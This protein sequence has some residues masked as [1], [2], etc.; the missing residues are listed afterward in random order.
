MRGLLEVICGPMFS[1]KSTELM[2]RVERAAIAKQRVICFKPP[3]DNR[4]SPD[5]LA[6][7]SGLLHDAMP[8]RRSI[9][10]MA[11][12]HR[13]IDVV[14]I[15]EAQ[16]VDVELPKF[17]ELLIQAD[18]TVILSGL[19]MDSDGNPFLHPVLLSR[20]DKITKLTAVCMQCGQDASM[21][22]RLS[23]DSS[24]VLVG[25]T[26][27]YEARCRNCHVVGGIS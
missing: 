11:I 4:Y 9:D 21:T 26:G 3:S 2:R 5:K 24:R 13:D 18:K 23:K 1:G 8:L 17:V 20:A 14:G 15:D 25:A 22:Q 16:F 19:D 7:H 12:S 6:S 27:M 10:L